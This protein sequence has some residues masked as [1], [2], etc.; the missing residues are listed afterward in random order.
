MMWVYTGYWTEFDCL[1]SAGISDINL[2]MW[3]MLLDVNLPSA[4]SVIHWSFNE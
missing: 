1:P 2:K 4:K 3:V